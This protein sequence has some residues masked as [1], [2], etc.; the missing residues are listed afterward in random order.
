MGHGIAAP[1][2]QWDD[3]KGVDVAGKILVLFTNEP[4]ST[5]PKFF[6]GRALTYY[7][8]WT[9]KYEEGAAPRARAESSS[10]TPRRPPAMAG[11][12]CAAPGAARR[13][14]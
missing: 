4:P 7:G 6:E 11:T 3:F 10:S 14:T 12:W 1:E 8:R 9:Y 13:R 5:D 2:W